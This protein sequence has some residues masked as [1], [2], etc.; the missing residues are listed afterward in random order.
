MEGIMGGGEGQE[1]EGGD[2][3]G[4]WGWGGSRGVGREEERIEMVGPWETR[5]P[6]M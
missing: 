4:F 2:D 5:K 3:C 1:G 6:R